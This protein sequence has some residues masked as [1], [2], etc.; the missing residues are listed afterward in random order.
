[1]YQLCK[2][3][4]KLGYH[5]CNYCEGTSVSTCKDL[6]RPACI[7]CHAALATACRCESSRQAA[8]P[9]RSI[10]PTKVGEAL[11]VSGRVARLFGSCLHCTCRQSAAVAGIK[12]E[13]IYNLK[14]QS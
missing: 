1:M 5:S 3:S 12:L 6:H 9:V 8:C 2:R 7:T 13:Q 4:F 11:D 10:L 14:E